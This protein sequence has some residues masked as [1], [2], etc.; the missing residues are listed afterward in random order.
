MPRPKGSKKDKNKSIKTINKSLSRS[1]ILS[2]P[3]SIPLSNII[4]SN[5]LVNDHINCMKTTNKVGRPKKKD[6]FVNTIDDS[7]ITTNTLTNS[8]SEIHGGRVVVNPAVLR[9]LE[10]NRNFNYSSIINKNHD[11]IDEFYT[12]D[13]LISI[14][15]DEKYDPLLGDLFQNFDEQ[16]SIIK[17]NSLN[18]FRI[19]SNQQTM[20]PTNNFIEIDKFTEDDLFW[21]IHTY[22]TDFLTSARLAQWILAQ[23]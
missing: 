21:D 16:H 19:Q 14:N 2:S 22:S 15:N 17:N 3:I 11:R 20:I 10:Q 23:Q 9:Y 12:R 7:M 6:D 18:D 8:S 13:T 4:C 1:S 5:D